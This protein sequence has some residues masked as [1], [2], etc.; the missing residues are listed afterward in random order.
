VTR[1]AKQL[2]VAAVALLALSACGDGGASA[3]RSACTLQV[4]SNPGFN[5]DTAQLSE[6]ARNA[7]VAR[8]RADLANEAAMSNDRWQVLSDASDALA[9]FA[10]LLE[11]ARM[12]GE[13]IADVTTPEL[14]DQAKFASD[15]LLA[16]CRLALR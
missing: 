6:L 11:Q 14:W 8:E 2:L 15:A 13:R 3:A 4:V 16:E 7:R 9:S 12:D 5:P 1:I 10:E